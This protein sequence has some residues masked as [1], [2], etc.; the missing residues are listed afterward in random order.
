MRHLFPL[1]LVGAL[2]SSCVSYSSYQVT[3]VQY[4]GGRQGEQPHITDHGDLRVHYN[5]WH[6]GGHLQFDLYN[7][8]PKALTL[9]LSR[10]SLIVNG[11]GYPYFEGED[12][13]LYIS[14]YQGNNAYTRFGQPTLT[15]APGAFVSLR[16]FDLHYPVGSIPPVKTADESRSLRLSTE[17]PYSF[18]NYLTYYLETD[19]SSAYVIDD[20]FTVVGTQV[21]GPEAFARAN[22]AKQQQ[23]DPLRFYHRR[24]PDTNPDNVC[25]GLSCL[26][27]LPALVWF[28][29]QGESDN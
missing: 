12:G 25:L 4:T 11:Q 15:I 26:I 17:A 13:S 24:D 28:L 18:R 21:M 10:S 20:P 3:S 27:G 23:L 1:L 29:V 19:P 9:D 7:Q 16:K 6:E 14:T 22:N 2:L 8:T 5:L